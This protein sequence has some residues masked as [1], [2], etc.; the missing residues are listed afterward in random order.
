MSLLTKEGNVRLPLELDMAI[1]EIHGIFRIVVDTKGYIIDHY[2]QI[3][4]FVP[5]KTEGYAHKRIHK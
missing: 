1:S 5:I 4:E 2:F 3:V